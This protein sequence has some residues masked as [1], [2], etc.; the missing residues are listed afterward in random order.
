MKKQSL[1]TFLHRIVLL[2]L[3]FSGSAQPG[4][5]QEAAPGVQAGQAASTAEFS[6]RQ[7]A[8]AVNSAV[9]P[10]QGLFPA[11]V[12]RLPGAPGAPADI[13]YVYEVEPNNTF[14]EAT[15]LGGTDVVARGY[16]FPAADED[17]FSFQ[18]NAGDRVYIATQ[19]AFASST[20][21]DS[22]LELLDTDGVTVLESDDNDGDKGANSSTISG[23]ELPASGVFY[24]K[25][26]H[27]TGGDQVRPYDLYLRLQTGSPTAEA[28]PNDIQ[29][30]ATPLPASGWITGTA[31][32]LADVDLF[33]LALNAGDTVYINLD[34]DP[35][36]DGV[37]GNGRVGLGNFKN[38]MLLA[39][40]GSVTS[41]NGE[42][43]FFTIQESD[44]YYVYVGYLASPASYHLSVSIHPAAPTGACIT[45][46]STDVPKTIPTGPDLVSSVIN[47]P[48][49]PRVSDVNVSLNLT[50]T[51]MSDLDVHL[52]SPGGNDNGLFSDIG[53][54]TPASSNIFMNVGIDDEAGLPLDSFL[55]LYRWIG[56]PEQRYRLDWFDGIDAGGTWTLN[57][58]DDTPGDGGVLSS[59]SITL[60]E[61]P[62]L[63]ACAPG[64]TPITVYSSD[65]ESDNGGFTHSGTADEWER[66]LPGFAPITS[67]ASGVNCW[68]TDLD[69]TYDAS[70]SQDLFSPAI[71]L[72]G[73][74]A[75]VYVT[76]MQKYQMENAG[77]D[78]AFAEVRQS[79]GGGER[80]L[81]EWLGPTMLDTVGSPFTNI[82]ESAGWGR[83]YHDISS[84]AG[85]Q[86]DLHYHLASDSSVNLGGYA[87]D[88]V[89]V[90]GCVPISIDVVKTVG[91]DSST[92]AAGSAIAVA[93]GT[94]V[95]YCYTVRNTG[96]VELAT[97]D[98]FDDQLG[99]LLTAFPYS[100]MPGDTAF[101]TASVVITADTTNLAAWTAY[102]SS[103]VTATDTATATVTMLG[104]ALEM[105]K[106]VGLDSSV[107]A[108][109]S[110]ISAPSGATV[111]YCYTVKNIGT[112]DLVTHDLVDDQ[113]GS[114]LNAFPYLLS[115]GA[116]V[117]ITASAVITTDTTN[118]A[119]WTGHTSGAAQASDTDSATVT[120]LKPAI[121]LV[122]TVGLDASTCAAAA[123]L[124]V[125][126]GTQVT[127]CY[128]VKNTGTLALVTHDLVD[129]QLGTLLSSFPYTLTP[130]SST[131]YTQSAVILTDTTNTAV[132]TAKTSGGL[133]AADTAG[134]T[135]TLNP[136]PGGQADL[137]LDKSAPA[138]APAGGTFT[139]TLSVTN[140]GPD[141]ASGVTVVDTL[142]AG[143]SFVSAS[144][145]CSF[146]AGTVTCSLGSLAGAASVTVTIIVTAPAQ[147]GVISN[148]AGVS[149]AQ[150]DPTP[151]NNSD[152]AAATVEAV[153]PPN[154]MLYL[155]VVAK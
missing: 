95:Y 21:G 60:C 121:D 1:Q 126:Y 144:A 116:T 3:L 9:E 140:N 13:G 79:G 72:S 152:S 112:I 71:D 78:V 110:S 36:R 83:F 47:I 150:S 139:Y 125:D 96:A 128:S 52:V 69:N 29:V 25:V 131:Y 2:V 54:V 59:W 138:T 19:T 146:A 15:P 66:G 127:Y 39:D 88:D 109:G 70:S 42:A 143:V 75:P 100:V 111:Y 123:S 45:Y 102:S 6:S 5:A 48:G 113:I 120:I 145:G 103:M 53:N 92:C 93:P 40:D 56:Q 90:T 51:F 81:W 35:E 76:W 84:Y 122:K 77:F 37:T 154:P 115:P 26:R 64:Y 50:H 106:T 108:S 41:P 58:Y 43:F 86:I 124:N 30:E 49:N 148:Q 98:L 97:H 16:V 22:F 107:C 61:P 119:T 46:T 14:G 153:A 44:I 57:I 31:A 80:K 34:L 104:P 135:V 91:V 141:A 155:P 12:S 99:P 27:P 7:N 87:V 149:A 73:L 118:I 133:S 89:S 63:P 38:T 147:P 23:R 11:G 151:G 65:F 114:V 67:C 33:S 20:G 142:P 55:I 136:P 10:V 62:P 4:Q 28:E 117:F 130:G 101:L 134:A 68:K 85:G 132:W 18:G 129:D 8:D 82:Q 137:A 105:T 24:V 17:F 74:S 94:R 32:S